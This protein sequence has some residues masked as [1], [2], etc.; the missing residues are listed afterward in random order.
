[1]KVS[2]VMPL[3]NE[4]EL[5]KN[6]IQSIRHEIEKSQLEIIVVNDNSTDN[7]QT[8][9]TAM[10]SE[11]L[12]DLLILNRK[13]LGHG[14]SVLRGIQAALSRNAD[15]IVTVDSDGQIS[16]EWLRQFIDF[17]KASSVSIV[18]GV[19]LRENEPLYRRIVSFFTRILVLIKTG[20]FPRDA[21]TPLRSYRYS[22]ILEMLDQLSQASIVPNLQLSIISRNRNLVLTEF[23]VV[24]QERKGQNSIG[25]T[26]K[27]NRRSVPSKKFI[28]FCV[29]AFL[30][31]LRT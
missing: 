8:V 5:I 2:L 30:E 21:N 15:L 10:E 3:F 18:E 24:S 11:G 17:A 19:R 14:P 27:S 26:W 7:S 22:I 12:I 16:A 13:N 28:K 20:R 6:Y 29:K 1:M 25:T 4:E 9:L 23:A 31:I